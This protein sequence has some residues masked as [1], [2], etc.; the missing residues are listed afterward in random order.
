MHDDAGKTYQEL[1]QENSSLKQRIQ[2]LESLTAE[3]K[4]IEKG[5]RENEDRNQLLLSNTT[6][7]VAHYDIKGN[8]LFASE[9]MRSMLGYDPAEL[10]GTSGFDRVHPDDRPYVREALKKIAAIE[11][12]AVSKVEYRAS[13]HDGSYKWVELIGKTFLNNQTGEL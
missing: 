13:C 8:L 4:R 5:L 9:A 12:G 7:Y 1:I 10:I 2:E 11:P 6:D 3:L